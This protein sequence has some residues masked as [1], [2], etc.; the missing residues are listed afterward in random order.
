MVPLY[1]ARPNSLG[2]RQ[3][4]N[5]DIWHFCSN[6]SKWPRSNYVE[7]WVEPTSGEICSECERRQVEGNCFTDISPTLYKQI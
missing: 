5:A 1:E 3:R 2:Y 4:Q 6:C 7:I